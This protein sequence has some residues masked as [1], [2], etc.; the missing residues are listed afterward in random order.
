MKLSEQLV[1]AAN[2][3]EEANTS[4]EMLKDWAQRAELLEDTIRIGK[5]KFDE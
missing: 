5:Y 4:P 1:W 2:N 3:Y